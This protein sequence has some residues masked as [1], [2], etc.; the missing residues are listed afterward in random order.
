MPSAEELEEYLDAMEI[1]ELHRMDEAAKIMDAHD[2]EA[3]HGNEDP[4]AAST[5]RTSRDGAAAGFRG[6][7]SSARTH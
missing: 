6:A 3:A 1:S 5:G 2:K 7:P 4:A